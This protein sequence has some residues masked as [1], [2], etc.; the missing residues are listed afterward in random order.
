[1]MSPTPA[2]KL[3]KM[4]QLLENKMSVLKETKKIDFLMVFGF[5]CF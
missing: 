1:M 5:F 3:N 2:K 4:K